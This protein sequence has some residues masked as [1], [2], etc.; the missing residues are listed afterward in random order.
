M[1]DKPVFDP[2]PADGKK[3]GEIW[4]R[5]LTEIMAEIKSP[6]DPEALIEDMQNRP[7]FM[8]LI[9]GWDNM[10]TNAQA[11]AWEM[12]QERLAEAAKATRPFCV[13]CGECCRQGSPVIHEMD[14]PALAKGA[15][16][17]SSLVTLRPGERAW[18]NR[19]RKVVILEKECIKLKEA[20]GGRTCI[21]L[22]PGGDACL[23]YPDRPHQC[24][25]M[26]CWDPSRFE[27][28]VDTPNPSRLD[29]IGRGTP[30][31]ALIERHDDRCD[32]NTFI[33]LLDTAQEEGDAGTAAAI[34]LIL[35]DL[36]LREFAVD[37]LN[38]PRN[39]LDFFFGR[40]LAA[41]AAGLG[42]SF[43]ITPEGRPLLARTGKGAPR[44]GSS[45]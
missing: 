7:D 37:K 33:G 21:F 42:F 43:T 39:E 40:P 28:L 19:T 17:R 14:R 22:G 26:E 9:N 35:Y 41:I 31:D 15:I 20:P 12:I 5:I 34:D 11:N 4:P 29:L 8:G 25:I 24:R 36:H 1:T 32:I 2:L 18:S 27:T 16:K 3:L 44:T 13:R 38:I 6:A 30:L 45:E 23:I 10:P